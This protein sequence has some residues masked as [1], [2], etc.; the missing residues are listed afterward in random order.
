MSNNNVDVMIHTDTPLT[1]QQF[2]SVA[3]QVRLI[4]GVSR[5]DRND[6]LPKVIMVNYDPDDIQALAI[7]SK[8]TNLGVGASLV[9]G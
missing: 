6:G 1:E 3:E 7:L 9:A 8:V 5:F 4:K 2:D